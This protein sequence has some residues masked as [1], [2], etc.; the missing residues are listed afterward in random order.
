MDEA[1]LV[2]YRNRRY[3]HSPTSAYYPA[4]TY[5]PVFYFFS[6]TLHLCWWW[7]YIAEYPPTILLS[8]LATKLIIPVPGFLPTF[9]YNI[10][11]SS[12]FPFFGPCLFVFSFYLLL[13]LL[14]SAC[15]LLLHSFAAC[16][17]CLL[18]SSA[19]TAATAPLF[20]QPPQ[21]WYMLVN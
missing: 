9:L 1:S 16:F 17:C 13:L 2:Y 6:S 14:L 19:A 4:D 20:V 18:L 7:G 10:L 21:L 5:I 15:Y 11:L 3:T 12:L 8:P